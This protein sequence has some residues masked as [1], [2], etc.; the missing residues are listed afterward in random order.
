MWRNEDLFSQNYFVPL[1]LGFVLNVLFTFPRTVSSSYPHSHCWNLLQYFFPLNPWLQF[2]LV[3]SSQYISLRL[4]QPSSCS[5]SLLLLFRIFHIFSASPSWLQFSLVIISIFSLS[6]PAFPRS[7]YTIYLPPH[8][9]NCN[10]SST[11]PSF[12]QY[13]R[14][15]SYYFT[16]RLPFQ[17]PI[18]HSLHQPLVPIIIG[19]VSC[20]SISLLDQY[21]I[22]FI[23][24]YG[25]FCVFTE[26]CLHLL[27][28]SSISFT[29]PS[30]L[31]TLFP[32][33]SSQTVRYLWWPQAIPTLTI[34][35]STHTNLPIRLPLPFPDS[36][37]HALHL[38]LHF[39][40]LL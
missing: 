13:A 26:G 24:Y 18:T 40:C 23:S 1:S 11:S 14:L 5:L 39:S 7:S 34:F 35:T 3:L 33:L 31:T 29:W 4:P 30:R 37:I 20:T 32:W 19:N 21:P 15:S 25:S 27:S 38:V 6:L 8:L 10:I 36:N 28:P 17:T 2:S 9:G 16:F 22:A 12:F